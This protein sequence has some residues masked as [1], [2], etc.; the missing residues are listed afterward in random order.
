MKNHIVFTFLFLALFSF[1]KQFFAQSNFY[2]SQNEKI[3]LSTSSESIIIKFKDEIEVN[4]INTFINTK[5]Y[6]K[7]SEQLPQNIAQHLYKLIL[8]PNMDVPKLIKELKSDSKIEFADNVYKINDLETIPFCRFLIR[9]K[10]EV[11]EEQIETL[12]KNHGVV[13]EKNGT[14]VNNYYKLRL[15]PFSDLNVVDMAKLYYETLPAV[16]SH[17]DFII[18]IE[19]QSPNDTFLTINIT[20]TI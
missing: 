14:V 3:F 5:E 8:Y 16:W 2:Y 6:L 18:P 7:D 20:F 10:P 19:L 9:F 17:P 15:T 1:Q 12:N 11:T 4:D 13:I